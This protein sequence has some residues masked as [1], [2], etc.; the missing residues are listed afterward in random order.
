MSARVPRT[1]LPIATMSRSRVDAHEVDDPACDCLVHERLRDGAAEEH[2]VVEVD[3]RL[4]PAERMAAELLLDDLCLLIGVGIAERRLHEEAVELRLGKR[5][6]SLVLD[7]VL[8]RHDEE[9]VLEAAGLAVDGYLLLGHRLEQRGL[10]LRHRAVDLVD[11][12]DV[13]EDGTG[14]EL[15][16]AFALV[17]DREPGDVGGLEVGRALDA[18]TTARRGSTARWR[19]RARSSR[20]RGRPRA[21]RGRRTSGRRRR[22]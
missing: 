22:A 17:E 2:H 16:V 20:C 8:R 7:R 14:S 6:R 10:G 5:E 9:R 11:E 21:A 12:H 1:E 15:E 19:G 3:R 4:E 18:A 13:R